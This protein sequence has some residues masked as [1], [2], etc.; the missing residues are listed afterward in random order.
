MELLNPRE[1][2]TKPTRGL[3]PGALF[4]RVYKPRLAEEKC[5]IMLTQIKVTNVRINSDDI[6]NI[7]EAK[8]LSCVSFIEISNRI[9]RRDN[10]ARSTQPSHE[11][12]Q[13]CLQHC[14]RRSIILHTKAHF[15]LC[16]V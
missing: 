2:R 16:S 3:A 13:M 11:D 10:F 12:V 9:D 5:F 8:Y 4:S 1:D 6:S 14:G 15:S 7:K